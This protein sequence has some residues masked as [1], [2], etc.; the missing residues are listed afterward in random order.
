MKGRVSIAQWAT[1]AGNAAVAQLGVDRLADRAGLG[2][3]LADARALRSWAR[4][5]RVAGVYGESPFFVSR[6]G[7]TGLEYVAPPAASRCGNRMR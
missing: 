1:V 5:E 7:E 4:R 2:G 6:V 3:A